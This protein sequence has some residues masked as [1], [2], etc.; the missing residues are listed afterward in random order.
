MAIGDLLDVLNGLTHWPEAPRGRNGPVRRAVD[1]ITLGAGALATTCAGVSLL[2]GAFGAASL[3][4]YGEF[5]AST[6]MLLVVAG[7]CLLVFYFV[8]SLI[9]VGVDRLLAGR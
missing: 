9:A 2:I 8:A 5:A 6:F 3:S 4:A 1:W 7:L